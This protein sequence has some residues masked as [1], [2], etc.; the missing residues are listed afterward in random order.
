MKTITDCIWIGIIGYALVGC[1]AST[2][3]EPRAGTAK[4]VTTDRSLKRVNRLGISLELPANVI[5]LENDSNQEHQRVFGCKSVRF[6]LMRL[7]PE[8]AESG[9]LMWGEVRIYD[10][11]QE[12]AYQ[13]TKYNSDAYKAYVGVENRRITRQDVVV[14][15]DTSLKNRFGYSQK[16]YRLDHKDSA[17]G[18]AFR[19]SIIRASYASRD[20]INQGDEELITQILKSIRFE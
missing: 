18:S 13:K 8:G 16:I 10:P 14:K 17:S 12:L 6:Q 9:P 5:D 7:A 4:I 11:Q 19:A 20:S 15:L 2:G 1:S 3:P